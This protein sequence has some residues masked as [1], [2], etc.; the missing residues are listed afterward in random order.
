MADM[1]AGGGSMSPTIQ[2]GEFERLARSERERAEAL[3]HPL[4]E[5]FG[6]QGEG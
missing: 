3:E 5:L 6:K 2:A 4:R 1:L